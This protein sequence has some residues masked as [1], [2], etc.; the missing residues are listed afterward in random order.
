MN[1]DNFHQRINRIYFHVFLFFRAYYCWNS[2]HSC[3]FSSVLLVLGWHVHSYWVVIHYCRSFLDLSVLGNNIGRSFHCAP[4]KWLL[5]LVISM[6]LCCHI[7]FGRKFCHGLLMLSWVIIIVSGKRSV[8]VCPC[9]P[10]L[11][12]LIMNKFV[13]TRLISIFLTLFAIIQLYISCH[14]WHN[15]NCCNNCCKFFV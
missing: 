13:S 14:C 15:L 1:T 6:V 9:R 10:W 2:F 11:L 5:S 3:Q 4:W 12:M 8:I 7:T